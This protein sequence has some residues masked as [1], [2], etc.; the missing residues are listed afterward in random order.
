MSSA[1]ALRVVTPGLNTTVQDLGRS[2]WQ[3]FGVPVSGALDRV[4]LAAA[5]IVV[6]NEPGAAALECLYQGPLLEVMADSV[7][8]AVA[9][10]GAA[11]EIAEAGDGGVPR[12]VPACE[13]VTVERGARV[14]G[15]I[16]APSMS[17]YLAVAG[18]IAV[19]VVMG[20][21]STLVRAGLGGHRGRALRAGDELPLAQAQAGTRAEMRLPLV[22][23][24]P[25]R[26]VRV[27]LGPQ[28]DRFTQQALATLTAAAFTVEPASDRMGLRLAGPPLT[29][30]RGPDIIS[31]AIAPGAIQVPG[32]GQPIIMLADRQTTGGYTKIATVISADLPA[33]GRVGPGAQLRFSAVSVAEA[34][35]L[36]RALD[37]EIAGWP[38]RLEPASHLDPARLYDRNLIS[39]VVDADG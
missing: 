31:D 33:L 9:G 8:L 22:D 14:R 13:S 28:D 4:A 7:R 23:L 16:A 5:N 37:A 38:H 10:A 19:P 32:S 34:E 27:V 24:S 25:A 3:R 18:G 29:H 21:R 39:G 2:G 36:R 20:S 12:R 1:P 17:A 35:A 30:T 11:L 26:L 6:G 15:V